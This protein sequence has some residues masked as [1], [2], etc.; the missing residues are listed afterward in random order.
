[1]PISRY[2][3]ITI[4]DKQIQVPDSAELPIQISYSLEDPDNFQSKPPAQALSVIV[5]ATKLNDIAANTFRNPDIIDLTDG[6]VFRGNQPFTVEETGLEIMTGKAFLTSASYNAK[7]ISYTF[8]FYGTNAAWALD[9]QEST[10]YD[11]LKDINFN[12]S[13]A[14]IVASWDFDGTDPDLPY[15]FAPVR[16]RNPM[17]GTSVDN[18]NN[19]IADDV[20][21]LSEYMRP[22]ISK[23]WIVFNAFKSLGYQ[24]KSAFMDSEYFRRQ[25]M[26]WTWGNFL[27]S[28]GTRLDTHKFLA[29]SINDVYYSF[30]NGRRSFFW[31]LKVSNDASTGAFDNNNDF[32]YDAST[33]TM[34]WTYNAPDYGKLNAHF[35]MQIQYDARLNGTNSEIYMDVLWYVNGVL[36]QTDPVVNLGGTLALGKQDIDLKSIFFTAKEVE[37]SDVVTVQVRL[38]GFASKLGFA[39]ITANII[40]FKLDYFDIPLGGTIYFNNYTGFQNYK[41]LDFLKGILDEFNMSI[42]TDAKN[43]IVY[44]EPTHPYST[45]DY[46]TVKNEGY[47]KDDFV[48]WDNKEDLSETWEMENYSDFSQQL[49]FAYKNDNND[50]ILKLVQDRNQVTLA[51][52]KYVFPPRFKSGTQK[53]EN[54]FFA[55]TMHYEVDQ[56]RFITGVAPQMIVLVPENISNTSNDASQNTFLPKSCYYK[57]LVSGVGG[58]KF[59]GVEYTSF[60][61]MFAVNYKPGGENDPILSYSDEKISNGAGSFAIGKGLLKRFYWQRLAIIRNGQWCHGWFR[62]KNV[63]VVDQLHREYISYR[64]HR[65]ELITIEGYRPLAEKSTQVLMRRWAPVSQE[66]FNNTYPSSA[67][68]L[69]NNSTDSNDTKYWQLKCLTSDIPT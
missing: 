56:L 8:D 13:T 6:N 24:I 68:V 29:K 61:F 15:V 28:D 4:G 22:S 50:G 59:N 65:W 51:S 39:S 26:P 57:G 12:F 52:G 18:K 9:L 31:D 67:N 54:T 25:V 40:E 34:K 5:P 43:K 10:L 53:I 7:P 21:M 3:K 36:K 58:W 47:F 37:D 1:V 42:N 11:F 14:G 19:I 45:V 16:Y 30:P 38:N 27:D 49:S 63:D 33:A 46:F 35:S 48:S 64:G 69:T 55:A 60:P 20:N 32:E 62:L 66:D 44:I 23:Y 17:G 2:L 41:F